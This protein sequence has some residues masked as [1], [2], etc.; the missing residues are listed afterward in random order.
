MLF[1]EKEG[2][3]KENIIKISAEKKIN[4]EELKNK[5]YENFKEGPLYYPEEYYTDQEMNLKI[6]EIIR[7]VTI[8]T[9]KKNYYSFI[10]R[11]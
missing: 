11:Y 4:I 3:H 7:G 2:I 5:I 10:C 9:L 8:K 1:L 6:S